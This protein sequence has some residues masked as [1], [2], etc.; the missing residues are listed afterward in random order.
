MQLE[1]RDLC[2]EFARGIVE[3]LGSRTRAVYVYGAVTFPETQHT[4]DIDFHA[5]LSE[6]PTEAERT[7]LLAMHER[8]AVDFPP[9]G[10]ELDGYYI[11]LDDARGTAR[12]RHLLFPHLRDDSWALHRAHI[13]AGRVIVLHGV[14]PGSI[15]IPPSWSELEEALDGEMGYVAAHLTEYPAYCVLNLCRLLYSW[16]TGDVVTSKAASAVW[17]L[18]HLPAWRPLIGAARATYAHADTAADRALLADQV[19]AF[20]RF[21]MTSIAE[22][23][24][25]RAG[26]S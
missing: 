25:R 19:D 22:A 1:I 12:P 5:I 3:I 4:G 16:E 23:Q 2:H 7:R 17:A 20:H 26:T 14:D 13:L 21:S 24:A 9:L 18:E 6:P 8:L 11:L 10:G 15:Y